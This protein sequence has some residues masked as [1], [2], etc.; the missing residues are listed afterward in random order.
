MRNSPLVP[1][2]AFSDGRNVRDEGFIGILW[3][4]GGCRHSVGVTFH[5][6]HAVQ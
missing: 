4:A 1:C 5:C 2:D 6:Q 3:E